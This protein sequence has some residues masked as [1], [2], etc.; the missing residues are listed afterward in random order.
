MMNRRLVLNGPR[1]LEWINGDDSVLSE[2]EIRVETHAC[3][4]S[5]G[6]EMSQ[7]LGIDPTDVEPVYP[8]KVGYESAGRVIEIGRSVT[9]FKVGDR[10]IAFYGQQTFGVTP[11]K[12]AVRIPAD[13]EWKYALLNTLSCDAAKGVLKLNLSKE[14]RVLVTGAGT[15]GVLAV[16][17]LKHHLGVRYVDVVEPD[18]ARHSL[19]LRLGA[20]RIYRSEAEIKDFYDAGLECSAHSDAFLTLMNTMKGEGTI[21][22]LS[23]GNRDEFT[24]PS[25]FFEKELR[26]VA[27]S[28]GYDYRKHSEWFFSTYEKTPYLM[29]LFEKEIAPDQVMSCFEEMASIRPLKVFVDYQ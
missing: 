5:I 26:M 21:C 17:F 10:V 25:A 27:S 8:R 11:S 18:E 16:H 14:D 3:G 13:V 24:L 4:I 28:D 9:D 7:Y 19:P 23:D 22:V 2:G 12:K 1:K 15:M 20:D 6:A 29:D